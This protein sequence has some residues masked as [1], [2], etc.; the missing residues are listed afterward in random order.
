MLLR[1]EIIAT[2]INSNKFTEFDTKSKNSD[3]KIQKPKKPKNLTFQ[4]FQVFKKPK[5]P[6]FFKIGLD[7]PG[8]NSALPNINNIPYTRIDNIFH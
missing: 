3:L 2:P 7:S 6:R 4:V 5:K 1:Y 8:Q